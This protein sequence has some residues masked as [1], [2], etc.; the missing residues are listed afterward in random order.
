MWN[1]LCSTKLAGKKILF[2]GAVLSPQWKGGEPRISRMLTRFLRENGSNV[3]NSVLT[4]NQRECLAEH[5]GVLN[6]MYKPSKILAPEIDL[7]SVKYYRQKLREE[8]PDVVFT[9]FDYDLSA[10]WVSIRM[11]IPTIAEDLIFWPLCPQ[12]SLFNTLSGSPCEGPNIYCSPCIKGVRLLGM[13]SAFWS[14]VLINRMRR[15]RR[16]LNLVTAIV[17]DSQYLKDLMIKNGYRSDL[18]HVIYNGVDITKIQPSYETRREKIVLFVARAYRH[19][20]I[21]HFIRLCEDL[22]PEFP[23]VKF[24]WVGQNEIFGKTFETRDYV[25]NEQELD[26]IYDSAYL[27]LLPSL[28]PEPMAYTVQEAMAHGKPV[29]AYDIGANGEEIINGETGFLAP[30]GNVRQLESCVRELLLNEGLVK[31]MGQK[32]RKLAEEKFSLDR[33]KNNYVRL[34]G[35]VLESHR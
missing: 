19:K 12:T 23:G 2:I 29:V 18:I 24:L 6:L 30:W 10:T 28:Y 15:L 17:S 11:K 25:W 3:S 31:T 13:R 22:K 5:A 8:R 16:R 20:G 21:T 26:E 32:A 4:R 7:P 33:M 34:V 27:L 1:P 9:W 14:T 35:K